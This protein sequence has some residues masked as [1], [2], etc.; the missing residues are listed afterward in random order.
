MAKGKHHGHHGNAVGI[1]REPF[2]IGPGGNAVDRYTLTN[3]KGMEVKILTYGGIIQEVW[4]PDRRR[5]LGNV[6]LGFDDP[7]GLRRKKA[8]PGRAARTSAAIIGRYGNRIAKGTFTLDGVTYHLPINN[9]PNSLHGGTDGFDNKVWTATVDLDEPRQRRPQ[10]ALHEP[11]RRGGLSRHARASRSTYT[12]TNHNELR[13]DY[14]ATTDKATVVNLTNH[15]YWNL[16]GEGTGDD[17]RPRPELN[18][19]H[20]TPVDSTLIP[21]GAIDPVAGTPIDFTQADGDRRPDP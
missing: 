1:K 15:S 21:T 18:A 6:T 7:R 14:H 12:L 13:I 19:D 5:P 4:V 8:V 11:G 20:Y 16:A 2:G 17:L 9:P 10:A 3:R